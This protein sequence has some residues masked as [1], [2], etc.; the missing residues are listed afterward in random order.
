[1]R[2]MGVHCSSSVASASMGGTYMPCAW[3]G[4]ASVSAE[5]PPGAHHQPAVEEANENV[6]HLGQE[7]TRRPDAREGQ[8]LAGVGHR[9][10][11]EDDEGVHPPRHQLL[12]GL[13]RRLARMEWLMLPMLLAGQVERQE[14]GGEDDGGAQLPGNWRAKPTIPKHRSRVSIIHS[15]GTIS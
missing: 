7:T 11:G 3:M 9:H 4:Y 15:M 14:H 1:M 5:V 2:A 13:E 8:G 12:A 6:D 10:H